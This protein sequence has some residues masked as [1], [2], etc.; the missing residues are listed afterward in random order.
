MTE[1]QAS[2]PPKDR[3]AAQR[4][5]MQQVAVSCV[6]LVGAMTG[7]AFAAVPLYDLFCSVTGFGGTTQLATAAPSAVLDRPITVRFDANVSVGLPVEMT[8][9]RVSQRTN[10]GETALITYRVRNTSD[11]RVT[12]IAG[13]NVTPHTTGIHFHKI[14]CFCFMDQVLEPGE[15]RDFPVVYFVA[16]ELASDL[17]TETVSTITLSYTLFRSMDELIERSAA[18]APNAL[19]ESGG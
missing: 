5:R 11:E 15:T 10:L 8:A 4:R 2:P 7:L 14:Q 6:A 17:N 9:E 16:P 13:Y 12:V 3:F 18:A 19:A 1:L